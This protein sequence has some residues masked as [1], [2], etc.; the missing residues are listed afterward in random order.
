M[1]TG[2]Q[3]TVLI[4]EDE[5]EMRFYLMTVVKSLGFEPVM[6]QDGSQGLAALKKMSPDLIVLDIMMPEKGGAL[7]YKELTASDR[8]R[9]IPLMIFSGVDRA[10]F[11]HYIKMLNA[12]PP[13]VN[14]LDIRYPVP[15]YYVEKSADPDYLKEMITRCINDPVFQGNGL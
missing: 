14:G 5:M 8:Y 1:A 13:D 2:D 6:T 9:Q 10:A 11:E 15:K 12:E 4:I 3:K 7:V